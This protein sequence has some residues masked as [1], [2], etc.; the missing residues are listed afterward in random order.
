MDYILN[1]GCARSSA[2]GRS[3][4][5]VLRPPWNALPDH[6]RT[7]PD[8]VKFRK[9]LI[10]VAPPEASPLWVDVQKSCNVC[11]L[12]LSLNFF[13]SHDHYQTLQIPYALQ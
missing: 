3:H 11:V 5:R 12:S 7:V 2:S 10:S 9:L 6:I 13:V 4:T 1:H 8:P